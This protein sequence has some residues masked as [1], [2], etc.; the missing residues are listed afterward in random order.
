V[1]TERTSKSILVMIYKQRPRFFWR[2]YVVSPKRNPF[3]II[4]TNPY[5][6]TC[7]QEISRSDHAQFTMKMI[8]DAIK[9]LYRIVLYCIII[10]LFI[11]LINYYVANYN[12]F[13]FKEI[14]LNVFF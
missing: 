5:N 2:L 11:F 6:H 13:I 1:E 10:Q 9:R 8:A 4:K 12:I 3:W 7:I 14:E